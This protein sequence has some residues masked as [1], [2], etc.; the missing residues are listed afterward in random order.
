MFLVLDLTKPIHLGRFE[1]FY[2]EWYFGL[3]GY[4]PLLS[5]HDIGIKIIFEK[6]FETLKVNK[7][8]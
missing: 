2:N 1:T 3:L 6:T 5:D 8:P 4:L 7:S